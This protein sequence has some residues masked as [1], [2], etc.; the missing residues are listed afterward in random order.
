LEDNRY[1]TYDLE[2]F[3]NIFTC[4]IQNTQNLDTRVFEISPRKNELKKLLQTLSWLKKENKTLVGYNNLNFDYPI[5][6][7]IFNSKFETLREEA[8]AYE[9]YIYA[10]KLISENKNYIED[11][12]SIILKQLDLMKIHNFDYKATMVSLKVLEINM[13]MENIEDLPFKP[14]TK[15]ETKDFNTLIKYNI[16]DVKATTKFFKHSLEAISFREKLSLEFGE[17]MMNYSDTKIGKRYFIRNLEDKLGKDICYKDGKPRQTIRNYINFSQIIFPYIK[18]QTPQLQALL[19][20]LKKQYSNNMSTV[21]S[22]IP[23]EDLGELAKHIQINRNSKASSLHVLF[24]SF[25]VDIGTGGLH[26]SLESC[27]LQ[28]DDKYTIIDIDVASYYPSIVVKNRLYPEHL[29]EEFADIYDEIRK[30][31]FSYNK[32]TSQNKMLKLALNSAGYGDTNNQYSPFYDYKMTITITLNGQLMLCL[33]SEMLSIK[34]QDL[35][36]I[37]ANT[38][39][40]TL[41]VPKK[42]KE[43]FFDI[44]KEWENITGMVLEES[45][46]KKIWIRDVNNYIALN[47]DGSVKKIGAYKDKLEWHQNHSSIVIQKA[48]EAHL[49]NGLSIEEFILNHKDPYDFMLN[50]KATR[51]IKLVLEN[52][53]QMKVTY[54]DL[55][56]TIRYYI[57]TNGKALKKILPPLKGAT[58]ERII[59]VNVGYLIN[60]CNDSKEFSFE[61]L[62]YY[63]Y[64]KEAYKLIEPFKEKQSENLFDY[65]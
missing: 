34:I 30:L 9:I 40:L 17:N 27:Y 14:G 43:L 26:G 22:N 2:T 60:I 24:D 44:L 64:I 8:I 32:K 23:R 39:G 47:E 48:V 3:P 29:G 63:W 54:E 5:L 52:K 65:V 58:E 56:K 7:Y 18:F 42:D 13:R 49:I 53:S 38:D 59:G 41:R 6:Q 15:L 16:H 31:R 12:K 50:Y 36:L 57:S 10:N 28:S 21:F 62:N 37:Q 20:Y 1:Y 19:E 51:G 55:Q 11:K 25:R 35:L 4:V 45:F 61:N 46:Y 33:L